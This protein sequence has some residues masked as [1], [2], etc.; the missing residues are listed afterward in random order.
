MRKSNK[1]LFLNL[2][3]GDRRECVMIQGLFLIKNQIYLKNNMIRKIKII[4][5]KR[6]GDITNK[7]AKY[8]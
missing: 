4:I 6:S 5:K 2:T 3:E 1:S 7:I 8:H